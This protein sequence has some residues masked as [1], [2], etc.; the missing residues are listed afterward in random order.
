MKISFVAVVR[1][2]SL[3]TAEFLNLDLLVDEKIIVIN[4]KVE[5]KESIEKRF[6][7]VIYENLD[8][9]LG[10]LRRYAIDRTSYDWVLMLD[11][12]ER[13]SPELMNE[14][15]LL[16][17]QKPEYSAY[18]IPFTNHLFGKPLRYGG[19]EYELIRLFDK[20]KVKMEPN[21]LHEKIESI[22][23]N[24][25]TLKGS[26][27][28]YSYV[29]L[30]QMLTKFTSYALR[31]ARKRK[32]N[33]EHT[34]FRKIV[35]YPLHMFYARYIEDGGYKDGGLRIILDLCFAYMEFL[36]Y[37]SMLFISQKDEDKRRS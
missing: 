21:L 16:K 8:Y 36:T 33:N 11:A 19:E 7:C 6:Q 1:S 4:S 23:N 30:L 12:D 18:I 31:D 32:A 5:D 22:D 2:A 17:K 28:H 37:T 15:I 13:L 35:L 14:I 29:S 9:D 10:K 27:L 24:M 20:R 25:G 26:I 3:L 34:S